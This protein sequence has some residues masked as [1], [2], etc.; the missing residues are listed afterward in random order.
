MKEYLLSV[1]GTVLFASLLLS[2]IPEGKTNGLIKSVARIACLLCILSPMIGFILKKET[3][4]SIFEESGIELQGEYIQYSNQRKVTE[5]EKLL[6]EELNGLLSNISGVEI[7]WET[8]DVLYNGYP[9]NEIK[10]ELI[11]I[12]MENSALVS[13]MEKIASYLRSEYGCACEFI[14]ESYA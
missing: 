3:L 9:R 14:S 6:A 5:T 1:V 7:V 4:S 10:I 13:E 11:R 8:Q 2:V 12:V